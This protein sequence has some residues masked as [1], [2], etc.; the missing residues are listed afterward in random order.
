MAVFIVRLGILAA[1]SFAFCH[2]LLKHLPMSGD[3]AGPDVAGCTFAVLVI[4]AWAGYGF[5][6]AVGGRAMFSIESAKK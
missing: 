5:Y 4:M 6:T 3:L 1:G 2:H